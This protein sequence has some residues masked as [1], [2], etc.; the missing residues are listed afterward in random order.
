MQAEEMSQWVEYL[1]FK[2]ENLSLNAQSPTK[3]LGVVWCV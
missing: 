3:Y 2:Y 1:P